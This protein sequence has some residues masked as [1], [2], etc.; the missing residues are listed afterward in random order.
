MSY[1]RQLSSWSGTLTDID[2]SNSIRCH[3]YVME[4]GI[5]LRTNTIPLYVEANRQVLLELL[6][7]IH[8]VRVSIPLFQTLLVIYSNSWV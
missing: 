6:K 4:N 7:I 2:H 1:T 3:A 5:C 8:L